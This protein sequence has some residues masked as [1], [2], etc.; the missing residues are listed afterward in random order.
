MPIH[1]ERDDAKRRILAVSSG[2]VTAAET[3][4]LIDRQAAEGAWTYHMLFD[5]RASVS[6]PTINDL[7]LLLQRVGMLTT[8]YGPRGPVAMVVVDPAL[9]E[10]TGR[11]QR[12]ADLTALRVELFMTPQEA[13]EWLATQDD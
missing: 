3:L 4:A 2:V 6:L 1:Y 10:I 8:K 13:E 12:L 11:Y 5:T 9:Y 7:R